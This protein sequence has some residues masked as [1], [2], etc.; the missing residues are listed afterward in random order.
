MCPFACIDKCEN[1]FFVSFFFVFKIHFFLIT[2]FLLLFFPIWFDPIRIRLRPREI[3]HQNVKIITRTSSISF[4]TSSSVRIKRNLIDHQCFDL[5]FW[6]RF[7]QS[8]HSSTGCDRSNRS[9]IRN[10]RMLSL[11]HCHRWNNYETFL[12]LH[13]LYHSVNRLSGLCGN[14]HQ[15]SSRLVLSTRFHSGLV[16]RSIRLSA[17]GQQKTAQ[18]IQ[19]W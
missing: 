12:Y 18:R 14:L 9:N 1:F 7:H 4:A 16:G 15:S 2:L 10:H 3:D 8:I 13:C 19:T 6:S 11:Y 17:L 5:D